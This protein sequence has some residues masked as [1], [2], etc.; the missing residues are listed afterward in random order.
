MTLNYQCVSFALQCESNESL[1]PSK[2]QHHLD[3][4]QSNL[5]DKRV[6]YLQAGHNLLQG[7]HALMRKPD[8]VCELPMKWSYPVSLRIAKMAALSTCMFV[9][10]AL[11]SILFS[12]GWLGNR[13]SKHVMPLQSQQFLDYSDITGVTEWHFTENG[14]A[15]TWLQVIKHAFFHN[16]LLYLTTKI[17]HHNS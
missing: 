5:R 12:I 6:Q 4:T 2:L 1:K 17:F 7:Q 16:R 3:T 9:L 8:K 10:F 15:S 11:G 13:E 14:G